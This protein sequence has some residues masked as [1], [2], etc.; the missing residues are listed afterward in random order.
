MLHARRRCAPALQAA[1]RVTPRGVPRF[2]ASQV[3]YA[4]RALIHT[5]PRAQASQ[6]GK[7]RFSVDRGGT[8][9]DLYA[10]VGFACV[11]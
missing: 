8:F 11:P 3:N 10:E 4:L 7:F 2:G 5:A 1:F 6:E 9:T